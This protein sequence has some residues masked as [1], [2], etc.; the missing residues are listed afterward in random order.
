MVNFRR[1][2]SGISAI[3]SDEPISDTRPVQEN[4]RD[5]TAILRRKGKN[6][7]TQNKKK[8]NKIPN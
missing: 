7:T 1:G 3:S 8:R 4:K 2:V 6:Y 5:T